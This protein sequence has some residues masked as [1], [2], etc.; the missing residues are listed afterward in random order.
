[1]LSVADVERELDKL[2]ALGTVTTLTFIDDT[3][4]VPKRRFK[5]LLRMMIRNRYDFKWN[6][7]YRADHGDEQAI[8]LMA[9][10]GC[11]GVFLGVESGSDTMLKAMNKT[12]RRKDYLKAIPLLQQ[13]GIS[14][15]ASLII[16]YPGETRETVDE[17]IDLIERAAPD[18]FR[19]QLW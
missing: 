15:Y 13:H 11:E 17:T 6:S 8:A 19:A 14:C 9:E 4:N 5:E 7:F 12:A 1:Y 16:G 3:F 18:Y 2:A 10:T